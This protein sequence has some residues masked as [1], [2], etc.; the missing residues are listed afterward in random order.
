M[1]PI[2]CSSAHSRDSVVNSVFDSG[3]IIKLV[4]LAAIPGKRKLG[5]FKGGIILSD[6]HPLLSH[7]AVR[8]IESLL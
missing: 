7:D 2:R 6:L 4:E 5:M 3:A 8:D 1:C